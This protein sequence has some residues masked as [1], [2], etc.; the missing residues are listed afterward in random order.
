[1]RRVLVLPMLAALLIMSAAP[2]LAQDGVRF[3]SMQ[4]GLSADAFWEDCTPDT[5]EVGLQT[6]SFVNVFVFDGTT[7][8]SE[9][10]KPTRSG[11]LACVNLAMVVV[12]DEGEFVEELS[13]ESGCNEPL[14]AAD[15]DVADDLST[16]TLETTI[17]VQEFVCDEETCEPVGDPRDVIV[18]VTWTAVSD[19]V[20]FRERNVSHSTNDGQKCSFMF[21]GDGEQVDANAT[22][23]V[24]GVTLGDSEFAQISRGK[25]SV[26]E[27]CH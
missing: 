19:V 15:L 20:A 18:D 26:S 11:S 3:A 27:H 8:F 16:A 25:Q 17:A 13:N 2:A 24:D 1:M 22:G 4:N 10:G 6:C 23:T 5:P 7:R 9:G 14:D 12:T 21:S